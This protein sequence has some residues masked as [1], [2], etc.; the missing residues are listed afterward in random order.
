MKM[1]LN[2]TVYVKLAIFS[3]GMFILPLVTYFLLVKR[4][5]TAWAGG[6]AALAA[7]VVL[8][9]YVVAAFLE[10]GEAGS[11]NAKTPK[12]SPSDKAKTEADKPQ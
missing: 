1:P 3:L 9:G 4:V 7:N 8:I 5:G 10:E 12:L 6:A 11:V 2:S